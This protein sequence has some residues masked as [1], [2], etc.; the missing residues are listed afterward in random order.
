MRRM[1]V[2]TLATAAIAACGGPSRSDVIVDWTF[3]GGKNCF[4]AGLAD[5]QFAI[6]N[7]VL[8][9]NHFVCNSD[10]SPSGV[11]LGIFLIG[12]YQLTISGVDGAGVVTHQIVQTLHVRGAQRGRTCTDASSSSDVCDIISIDVPKVADST[13]ALLTW[14]FSPG[15]DCATANVQQV[16]I[17]VDPDP[18]F[19]TG[20]AGT[21]ACST[22][23]T[24][25]ASVAPLTPGNH[26]FAIVGLRSTSNGLQPV[27]KTHNLVQA[28]F[29]E[30]LTT[31]VM[32]SAESPP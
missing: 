30:G 10:G 7:E 32:V 6:D 25:G 22:M 29:V 21:V 5:I 20:N 16:I 13:T 4:D 2:L 19:T 31:D 17:F 9:P 1:V 11:G 23:G 24:Q 27:Y 28:F 18:N 3:E 26:T 14:T 8:D 15:P 12:D